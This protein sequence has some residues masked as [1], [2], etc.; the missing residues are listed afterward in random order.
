M[1]SP[2]KFKPFVL[3]LLALPCY[4]FALDV[5]L[6]GVFPG[7]GAVL[8]IDGAAP[9]SVKIG[10]K[11]AEGV[12]LVSVDKE[13]AVVEVDGNKKTLK[14]GQHHRTEAGAPRSSTY[15]VSANARGQFIAAGMINDKNELRMLID[16]GASA[17]SIPEK[18]AQ[19]MGLDYKNGAPGAVSTANGVI[20]VWRVK[21]ASVKLGDVSVNNIDA[22]V[23]PGDAL[24]IALLGMNFLDR[25]EMNREGGTMTLR[26]RF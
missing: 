11:S 22:V 17:I 24:P 6:V 25:F 9:K 18:D 26:K 3:L 8:V 4:A 21:L 14:I 13:T 2:A 16:T 5:S 12:T 1:A 20:Q 19:R 10:Q 7:K 15:S 23:I